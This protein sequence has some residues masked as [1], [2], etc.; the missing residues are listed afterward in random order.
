LA[1]RV[2]PAEAPGSP[3]DEK[4]AFVLAASSARSLLAAANAAASFSA[5]TAG[6]LPVNREL[7]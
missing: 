6:G 4:P 5:V 1:V 3:M 2:G 7:V